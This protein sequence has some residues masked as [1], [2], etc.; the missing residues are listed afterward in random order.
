VGG[1]EGKRRVREGRGRGG[2]RGSVGEKRG[3]S[4][5]LASMVLGA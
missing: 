4:H 2:R 3:G 5:N 1:V